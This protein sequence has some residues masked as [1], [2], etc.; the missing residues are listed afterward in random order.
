MI[1]A[2]G[3]DAPIEVQLVSRMNVCGGLARSMTSDGT[4]DDEDFQRAWTSDFLGDS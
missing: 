4:N 3:H 2:N 1:N